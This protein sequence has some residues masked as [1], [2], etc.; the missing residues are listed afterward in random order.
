MA[1]IS[2]VP[3]DIL[4][5]L[6]L[7]TLAALQIADFITTRIV[8]DRGGYEQNP[9]AVFLMKLLTVDGFLTAKAILVTA[10]G[11]MVGQES[12][13]LLVAVTAFYMWIIHHNLK[14]IK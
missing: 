9:V 12:L 14:S 3:I 13:W 4:F 6:L 7:V 8:L 11:Y 1:T 2:P 10:I 5:W